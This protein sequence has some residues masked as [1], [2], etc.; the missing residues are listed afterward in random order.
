MSARGGPSAPRAS[1]G[2]QQPA[3]L[4]VAADPAAA[5]DRDA[6]GKGKSRL[7]G[8]F[9]LGRFGRHQHRSS[10]ES[11]LQLQ[12]AALA[13]AMAAP[14]ASTVAAPVP[15]PAP[16]SQPS[17]MDALAAPSNPISPAQLS[18]HGMDA[19]LTHGS[20]STSSSGSGI[21]LSVPNHMP[22]SPTISNADSAA[23]KRDSMASDHASSTAA[24]GLVLHFAFSENS[25][26]GSLTDSAIP[27][28]SV[29]FD[30]MDEAMPRTR[31][32]GS[33]HSLVPSLPSKANQPTQQ[34]LISGV[35][36]ITNATGDALLCSK[37]GIVMLSGYGYNPAAKMRNPEAPSAAAALFAR[38]LHQSAIVVFGKLTKIP[39]GSHDIVFSFPWPSH[40]PPTITIDPAFA[41]L[42]ISHTV[43][44]VLRVADED[45]RMVHSTELRLRKCIP[46]VDPTIS[47]VSGTDDTGDFAY[48]I[49]IPDI[50]WIQQH[51]LELSLKLSLPT[52]HGPDASLRLA[53]ITIL[54][55]ESWIRELVTFQDPQSK[56]PAEQHVV[57]TIADEPSPVTFDRQA[58]SMSSVALLASPDDV[59]VLKVPVSTGAAQSSARYTKHSMS[60]SHQLNVGI[61]YTKQGS[62]EELRTAICIPIVLQRGIASPHDLQSRVSAPR[63]KP[64]QVAGSAPLHTGSLAGP[65]PSSPADSHQ[66]PA[67]FAPTSLPQPVHP[68]P[69]PTVATAALPLPDTLAPSS[70][71]LLLLSGTRPY[72]G[73]FSYSPSNSPISDGVKSTATPLPESSIATSRSSAPT[74]SQLLLSE[75]AQSAHHASAAGSSASTPTPILHAS[76]VTDQLRHN[77]TQSTTATEPSVSPLRRDITTIS[78]K[79]RNLPQK[80][81][82]DPLSLSAAQAPSLS[83][84]PQ[85]ADGQDPK[86][87]STASAPSAL[88]NSTTRSDLNTPKVSDVQ[89]NHGSYFQAF[90]SQE[91]FVGDVS[92]QASVASMD[93]SFKGLGLSGTEASANT[94]FDSRLP[95]QPFQPRPISQQPPRQ[96]QPMYGPTT[97]PPI[98]PTHGSGQ[99]S[100]AYASGLQY[101]QQQPGAQSMYMSMSMP[102]YAPAPLPSQQPVQQTALPPR[103]SKGL[104]FPAQQP[105]FPDRHDELYVAAGDLVNV[106]YL[107]DA[108]WAYGTNV[109]RGTSGVLPTSLFGVH[110]EQLVIQQLSSGQN[111]PNSAAGPVPA[112]IPA[113]QPFSTQPPPTPI[114]LDCVAGYPYAPRGP[115]ELDIARGDRI[116]LQ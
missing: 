28:A 105:H 111:V 97:V 39:P 66:S 85:V 3:P 67:W 44:A 61:V 11:S 49:S 9:G 83:T 26:Q 63:T 90:N 42:A 75:T 21:A 45:K 50:I 1:A 19:S 89:T 30:A 62:T 100:A 103:R 41:R 114:P 38:P 51:N 106:Q 2:Q 72:G 74:D 68:V 113:M 99:T 108:G 73:M 56:D 33:R 86:A 98:P 84:H 5:G 18:P 15:A 10:T 92:P 58:P 47:T 40:L 87:A 101:M 116:V 79:H 32:D 48:Q 107:I 96:Q 91:T 71:S 115:S 76:Y 81:L 80:A 35:L 64:S 4:P 55:A 52:Q 93:Q 109:S 14:S 112:D 31:S 65:L 53:R 60:I 110:A 29:L 37:L 102:V 95:V 7:S 104:V 17:S 82:R 12:S 25:S 57:E 78:N 43:H 34:P 27:S 20:R 69:S 46:R 22:H 24:A 23:S 70:Q 13:V 8:I 88:S 16:A 59:L 94:T 6:A 36:T 54:K 77:P